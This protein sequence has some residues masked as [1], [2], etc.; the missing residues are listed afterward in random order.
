[1]EEITA[2]LLAF[3]D[4]VPDAEEELFQGVYPRLH[5][6]AVSRMRQESRDHTLQPTALIHETYMRLRQQRGKDWHN[7]EHF[8]AVAAMVM[9]QVLV[10]HARTRRASKRGSGMKPV[11]L[12]DAL[13]LT[14]EQSDEFVA[15]H[16]ALTRLSTRDE[17]QARI[18][19]LKFL[20][21]FTDEQV[22]EILD[23]A[24]KTV[25]RDWKIAKAWLLA[26]LS[27]SKR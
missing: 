26:E 27:S 7:R 5:H 13:L 19:E 9:R 4:C 14:V 17:R 20:F 10:D 3:R 25:R 15:L 23:V 2:L 21:G 8:Y 6:I 24:S 22:A 11:S 16:E 1:V 18:V 12:E